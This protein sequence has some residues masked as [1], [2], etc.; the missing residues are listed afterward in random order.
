MFSVSLIGSLCPFLSILLSHHFFF[1]W[2]F[3][4]SITCFYSRLFFFSSLFLFSYF[5]YFLFFFYSSLILIHSLV[6]FP[7]PLLLSFGCVSPLVVFHSLLYSSVRL[8]PAACLQV[9]PDS[10]QF[11][12]Y[13]TI[14]LNCED[15]NNSSRW[16]V[17]R[18]TSE[19]G[20][21]SCASGWG[22]SSSDSTCTI[23]NIY[24]S[25]SGLY[26]C[27]S[28]DGERSGS[29]NI[30]ITDRS[31]ILQSPTLPLSEGAAVT[32]HC[33][34][35]SSPSRVFN[36]FKD[37]RHIGNSS[38]GE[39]S[40][41]RVSKSDEGLYKCSSSGGEESLSSWLT[42]HASC[43]S[44]SSCPPAALNPSSVFRLMFHLLVG[45][46]YLLSTILLGL[47]YRDR[48][49]AART[50]AERSSHDVIMEIEA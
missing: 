17:K 11:F 27:E 35:T 18:K 1:S 6:S 4:S 46:P 37:G 33:K 42:V 15:L 22:S 47:I 12:M 34:E 32:L 2:S 30:T 14:S 44:S 5:L 9:S 10:S 16:K 23:G 43:P 39:M 8:L 20:L 31:V 40:I 36:F 49:R 26:W 21:R 25:D 13:D 19:S 48:K 7:F 50:L 28:A 38:S 24:P 41:R 3:L 45:T 29:V